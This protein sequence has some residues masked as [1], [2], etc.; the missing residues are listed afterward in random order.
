MQVW[1]KDRMVGEARVPAPQP[2]ARMIRMATM[3]ERLPTRTVMKQDYRS[4]TAMETIGLPLDVRSLVIDELTIFQDGPGAVGEILA[5]HGVRREEC[6]VFVDHMRNAQIYQFKII[7]A[8]LQLL[9]EIF[10]MPWFEPADG[11]RDPI[12]YEQLRAYSPNYIGT[13]RI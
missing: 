10:D 2:G 1:F 12:F 7:R 6:E 8:N 3:G 13:E 11:E 9:E 4:E 5:Q